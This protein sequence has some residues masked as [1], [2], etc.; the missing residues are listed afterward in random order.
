MKLHKKS[1]PLLAVIVLFAASCATKPP[2]KPVEP[3]PQPPVAVVVPEA[4]KAVVSQADVD[5]LRAQV[6]TLKKHAFDFKLF[7][8]L[9]DAYKGA[10]DSYVVAVAAY[11]AKDLPGA[12]DKFG[13]SLALYK[14]LNDKGIVELSS[15]RRKDAEDAKANAVKAGADTAVPERFRPAEAAL[16]A[17]AASVGKA[18]YDSAIPTYERARVLYELSLKR[19]KAASLRDRVANS[20]FAVWDAGNAKTADAKYAEE[21]SLFKTL[22]GADGSLIATAEPAKFAPLVDALDEAALR[23]NLV[24]QKAR[25]SIATGAKQKSDDSKQRSEGI[26]AN[27]AAKDEYTAA[28]STYQAAVQALTASD[29]ETATQKFADAGAAFEKAYAIAADKRAKA[30]AEMDAAAKAAEQALKKAQEADVS[31]A[32]QAAAPDS[33]T[34][35]DATSATTKQ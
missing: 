11:D 12:K 13:A 22:G 10:N 21:D 18:D 8:V 7:E 30:A 4:P 32:A 31:V 29:Y 6:E 26:K 25:T 27:V 33:G 5:A 16:A 14:D 34:T 2:A 9:P 23:Y 20:G 28:L 17:A 19:G 1:L 3:A 24:I 15:L 35:V